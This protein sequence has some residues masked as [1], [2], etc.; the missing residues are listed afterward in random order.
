ML[1][2]LLHAPALAAGL[3]FASGCCG[4]Y[5]VVRTTVHDHAEVRA[6]ADEPV[7][8]G[9]EVLHYSRLGEPANSCDANVKYVEDLWIQLPTLDAGRSYTIG[10]PGVVASYGRAAEGGERVPARSIAGTV[11]IVERTADGVVA[12]LEIQI[13][14]PSGDV[15]ALDDE[16]AFH[17]ARASQRGGRRVADARGLGAAGPACAE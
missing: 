17:A 7:R 6:G 2:A 9:A 4:G 11:T 12:S 5:A 3:L 14:L 15:V 1:R 10:A 8:G 13:A 16:Y